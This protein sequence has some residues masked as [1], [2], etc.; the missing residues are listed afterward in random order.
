MH[1]ES[2]RPN[3]IDRIASGISSLHHTREP[4][5]LLLRDKEADFMKKVQES[6]KYFMSFYATM[7]LLQTAMGYTLKDA[8]EGKITKISKDT[9]DELFECINF[10]ENELI[11]FVEMEPVNGEPIDK[12][13]L[14]TMK[15]KILEAKIIVTGL[16]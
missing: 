13:I 12:D 2:P 6:T 1:E 10:A 11:P 5:K 9:Y 14:E 15:Q 7:N 4:L 8:E 16:K 3:V